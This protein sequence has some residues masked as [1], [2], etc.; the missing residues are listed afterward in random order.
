[1]NVVVDKLRVDRSR[2][3]LAEVEVGDET[4]TVSLRARDDQIDVLEKVSE[5]AGSV[6]LR[7]CTLELFQGK[8]IRLAITKWGKLSVFPDDVA[9]TPPPPSKINGDRNYSLIDLSAVASEMVENHPPD[10]GY[11]AANREMPPDRN[12]GVPNRQ[13]FQPPQYHQQ[14]RNPRDRRQL[15]P[16]RGVAT[17]PLAVPFPEI[18]MPNQMRY[19]GMPG[20]GGFGE[21]IDMQHYQYGAQRQNQES[22]Q[23]T[24]HQMLQ[25]QQQQYEMQQRQMQMHVF[26]EHGDRHRSMHR[27]HMQ[28]NQLLGTA[29][30][31][32]GP[33]EFPSLP[34]IV[35]M[36]RGSRA[37]DERNAMNPSARDGTTTSPLPNSPT[38]EIG[39]WGVR[40]MYEHSMDDSVGSSHMN[41]QAHSFAPSY[42][43]GKKIPK[44]STLP[45]P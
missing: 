12:R 33:P 23:P 24:P 25:I 2:V 42:P 16:N 1:V 13:P 36:H 41:P 17:N 3:R 9:S 34:G 35:P 29:S 18:A 30:F 40:Q 6:V 44:V 21:S 7:N 31:D 20:Y 26:H 28:S 14:R 8:H 38:S 39:P 22:M 37:M 15:R 27:Q 10:G 43:K 32:S 45:V 4:G 11:Q 5:S 19:P